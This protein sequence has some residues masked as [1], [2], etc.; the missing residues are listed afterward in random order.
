MITFEDA[1]KRYPDG[2]V[3]VAGLELT[4]ET[5]CT[6]VFVG[7]VRWRCASCTPTPAR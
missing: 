5:G 6:T 3:A 7:P 1:A 4:V 2:T